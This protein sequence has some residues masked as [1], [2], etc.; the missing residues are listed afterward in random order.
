MLLNGGSN[1]TILTNSMWVER[2]S[3]GNTSVRATNSSNHLT[4]VQKTSSPSRRTP[5]PDD[6]DVVIETSNQTCR[7]ITP[8]A[9][10]LDNATPAANRPFAPQQSKEHVLYASGTHHDSGSNSVPVTE[11][12]YGFD[13]FEHESTFERLET[14][15]RHS[16]ARSKA[17][18]HD[19]YSPATN[20]TAV[21][22][23]ASAALAPVRSASAASILS[24]ASFHSTPAAAPLSSAADFPGSKSIRKSQSA[25][26]MMPQ[27]QAQPKQ[28]S[29]LK[30]GNQQ[31]EPICAAVAVYVIVSIRSM[32]CIY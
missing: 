29:P 23:A 9:N 16:T 1:S 31:V 14:P 24:P 12:D 8:S 13:E 30:K 32:A 18:Y 15:G 20:S 21:A 4:F 26:G 17:T 6:D 22:S 11:D 10:T 3:N 25:A 7:Y 27:Q 5:Q 28:L 2:N 19:E